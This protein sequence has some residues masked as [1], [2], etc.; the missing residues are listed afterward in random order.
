MKKGRFLE[1]LTSLELGITVT[2]IDQGSPIRPFK[3]SQG[4]QIFPDHTDLKLIC[5]RLSKV[6]KKV[7]K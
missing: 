3:I 2:H 4:I 7:K 1:A 6:G 5:S